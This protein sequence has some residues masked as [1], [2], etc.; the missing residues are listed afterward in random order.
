MLQ[1]SLRDRYDSLSF[2]MR[3]K[4]VTTALVLA[5]TP[6]KESAALVTLLTEEFGLV[7]AR[8]EGLRKPG[9]KLAHALQTFDR[10]DVT[11]VRGKDGW[12]LAGAILEESWFKRLARSERLRAGRV[13]GLLLRLVH[14]EANDPSLFVLFTEFLETL[15][16]LSEEAQDTAEIM[17]ALRIL[18]V[19]GLDVGVLPQ[20]GL[21]EPL[22]PDERRQ[23]VMRVNRGIAASGL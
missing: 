18:F 11:L 7:R 12:R 6:L 10:C 9:A 2:L 21:Y 14:G 8:A 5:R 13:A 19:L 22:L 3:H 17:T 15:P 4:Y 1:S 23:L 16:D 20:V